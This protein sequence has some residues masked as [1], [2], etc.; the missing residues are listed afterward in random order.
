MYAQ[1]DNT[2]SGAILFCTENH[3]HNDFL[4]S[5]MPFNILMYFYEPS[6]GDFRYEVISCL[7]P[8]SG[9]QIHRS[10]NGVWQ[11]IWIN[12]RKEIIF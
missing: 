6:A 5:I 2:S 3:Y 12:W 7:E 10:I 11:R 8:A 9:R 4:M 1:G